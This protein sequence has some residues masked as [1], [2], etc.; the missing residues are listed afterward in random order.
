MVT[1]EY[2]KVLGQKLSGAEF[3]PFESARS[4]TWEWKAPSMKQGDRYLLEFPT[5]VIVDLSPDAI[6]Q[7]TVAGPED[8]ES[9]ARRIIESL[10]TTSEPECYWTAL[11]TMLRSIGSPVSEGEKLYTNPRHKWSVSYP[12]TWTLDDS[13]VNLVVIKPPSDVGMCGVHSASARFTTVGEFADLTL[14]FTR[15]IFE[16]RGLKQEVTSRRE[17]ALADDVPVVD[18]A[19]DIVPGGRGRRVFVLWRGRGILIDCESHVKN[20][21]SLENQYDQIISSFTLPRK[22][23]KEAEKECRPPTYR[24][25]RDGYKCAR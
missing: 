12:D 13:N 14:R 21:S 3:V 25:I 9:L 24:D 16:A 17:R 2:E 10:K 18:V 19:V 4:G 5:K 22:V 6:V 8:G 20:W 15:D 1:H 11:E 23:K 7:I